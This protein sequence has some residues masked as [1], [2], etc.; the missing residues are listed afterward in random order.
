M[1]KKKEVKI[2]TQKLNGLLKGSY[3]NN[4]DAAKIADQNGFKLDHELSNRQHKVYIDGRGNP[5]VA[6][7]GT[8]TLGDIVT[9]GA[10]A[11]GL[12]R[13][14]NRF[15]E[16]KNLMNSVKDKYK[17]RFV[18]TT[19]DS[20]GG[21]LAEHSG[22]DKVIT[23]NKG[24]GI[25]G[26]LKKIPNKQIDIRAGGDVVSALSTTQSGGK[27][28]TI[29]KTNYLNPLQSHDYNNLYKIDRKL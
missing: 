1:K 29:P 19:G 21:S 14:T 28:I 22:G 13:F 7:T 3:Q 16:S 25:D 26:L 27:R 8:R 24:V 4:K 9:D 5:T 23:H 11:I 12:G 2:S 20:L 17:N 6:Y 18:T 10:L 15:S